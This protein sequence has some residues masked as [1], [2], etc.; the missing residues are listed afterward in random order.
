M[1]SNDPHLVMV[2]GCDHRTGTS[3]E[4]QHHRRLED[5]LRTHFDVEG[6]VHRWSGE[7]FEPVDGL[8]MIGAA[9]GKQNVYI[10]TG[11]SGVG[12]TWGTAAASL[13]ADIMVGN[14][15]RLGRHLSP[16]RSGLSNVS[17]WIKEQ[18][19]TTSNYAEHLLPTDPIRAGEMTSGEGMTGSLDGKH[20]AY[21]VDHDGCEH[22]LDP[23][24]PHKG[25]VLH[26]NAAE[27][28]WD[29]PVHGGRFAAD[30]QRIYGPP[31]SNM[32]SI[33]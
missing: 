26:W 12:L 6:I 1:E 2:G 25:G 7:P 14:V 28:T 10:A 31:E 30:G 21:C 19:T 9:P 4:Q 15:S 20:V 8:P 24:C 11:L 32:K 16:S 18:A 13:L 17:Q 22:R 5:W 29:C 27:Q 3:D 23:I 33:D